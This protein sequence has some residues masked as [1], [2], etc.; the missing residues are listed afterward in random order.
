MGDLKLYLRRVGGLSQEKI[1]TRNQAD[2]LSM[3]LFRVS[4]ELETLQDGVSF[5]PDHPIIID[6]IFVY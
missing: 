1:S 5:Y 6:D 3:M 2:I 4:E